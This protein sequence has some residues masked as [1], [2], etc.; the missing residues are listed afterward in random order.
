V[1]RAPDGIALKLCENPVAYDVGC[2]LERK[3][4]DRDLAALTSPGARVMIKARATGLLFKYE[5]FGREYQAGGAPSNHK[6]RWCEVQGGAVGR[7]VRGL[8]AGGSGDMCSALDP[9]RKVGLRSLPPPWET[10]LRLEAI[11]GPCPKAP[12][13][14]MWASLRPGIAL[15][16][17]VG[18]EA[19][20]SFRKAP[21]S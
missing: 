13:W 8:K 3:I 12:A 7:D 16:S 2:I 19:P 10:D 5:T 20:G 1:V 11:A 6:G 9:V 14:P 4:F 17:R 18:L 21:A 15:V